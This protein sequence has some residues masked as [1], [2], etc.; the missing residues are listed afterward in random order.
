MEKA[1][2][3]F[4]CLPNANQ[5]VSLLV[6][7]TP[8]C[9]DKSLPSH[10]TPKNAKSQKRDNHSLISACIEPLYTTNLFRRD[11]SHCP[12]QVPTLKCSKC[13]WERVRERGEVRESER[14]EKGCRSSMAS[15]K[16]R[17]NFVYIAKLAEQAERYEGPFPPFSLSLTLSLTHLLNFQFLIKFT[18]FYLITLYWDLR[19]F[20]VLS[21]MFPLNIT[22]Y[23][24]FDPG[25]RCWE[26]FV[27]IP[28]KIHWNFHFFFGNWEWNWSWVFE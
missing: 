12:S 23:F 17:E 13:Y 3:K 5:F 24:K 7:L 9:R 1:I 14:R 15:T 26:C 27:L 25:L 19:V 28:F 6:S 11:L 4:Q 2:L 10:L 8:L 20:T 16:E 21:L 22:F 18:L